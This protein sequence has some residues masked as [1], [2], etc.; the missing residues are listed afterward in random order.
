MSE[1]LVL[2]VVARALMVAET[3]G[4]AHPDRTAPLP[5]QVQP[6]EDLRHDPGVRRAAPLY[7]RSQVTLVFISG[8]PCK[9]SSPLLCF[10]E[11]FY[12]PEF[13]VAALTQ[14][15]SSGL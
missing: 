2:L 4:S 5:A 1:T 3:G 13:G 6:V 8:V 14:R 10:F 15:T 9:Q 12:W 7:G 11:G